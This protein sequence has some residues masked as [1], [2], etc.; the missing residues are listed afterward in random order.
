MA[1]KDKIMNLL[2][3][4]GRKGIAELTLFMAIHGFYEAPCSSKYHL[5]KEGG[6]AEH[7]LNVYETMTKMNK[8][9]NAGVDENSLIITGLL[10]DVGKMG[11]N[12]EP[13]YVPAYEEKNL[14]ISGQVVR[15]EKIPTGGFEG[16]KKLLNI[17]HEFISVTTIS[18]YIDLTIDEYNA[19]LY[20][21]GLYTPAGQDI[22][23]KETPLY[24][25]LHSADMWAARVIERGK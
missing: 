12:G 24:L 15:T 10:H 9:L 2:N 14:M 16:N 1:N 21:N 13:Y 25:L 20:H 5:A 11:L 8:A 22:K 19:I 18:Q 4:T 23:G 17:R 6:L 7:S 3:N